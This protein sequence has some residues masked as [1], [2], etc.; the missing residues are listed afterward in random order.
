MRRDTSAAITD[1]AS[2]SSIDLNDWLNPRTPV[3]HPTPE[4]N[5][6]DHKE[7]LAARSAGFAN[8]NAEG[9]ALSCGFVADHETIL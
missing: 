8:C 5:G 1:R 6:G 9:R 4:C 7:K 3:R 2:R